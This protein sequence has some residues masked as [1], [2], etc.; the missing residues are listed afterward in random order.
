M[1]VI[2]LEPLTVSVGSHGIY[3]FIKFMAQRTCSCGFHAKLVQ[4]EKWQ[5]SKQSHPSADN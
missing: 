5:Q 4:K 2:W 3:L 1:V